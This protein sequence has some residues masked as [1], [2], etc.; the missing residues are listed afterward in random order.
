[1]KEEVRKLPDSKSEYNIENENLMDE[2]NETLATLLSKL[3]PN[4]EKSLPAVMIGKIVTSVVTT[5]FT[6]L[7]LALSVLVSDRKLIE[8]LHEYGITSTYQEFRR[9]K[10]S[11]AISS[12]NNDKEIRARNCLIQIVDD[13]DAH[14]PERG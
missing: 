9:F 10:V 13:F 1:M 12:D 11:A 6:K 5:R 7:Q 2:C 4:F 3:S 14:V 8:H